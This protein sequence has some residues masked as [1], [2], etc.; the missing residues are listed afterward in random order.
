ME[1]KMKQMYTI[2]VKEV[3]SQLVFELAS[4]DEAFARYTA[5]ALFNT[6]NFS[7]VEVW[8]NTEDE[9]HIV[10]SMDKLG[11]NR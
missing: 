7:S 2:K 8:E 4:E 11:K 9:R 3:G 10:M 6:G 5:L 1:A